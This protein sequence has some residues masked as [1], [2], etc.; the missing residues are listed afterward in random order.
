MSL[1]LGSLKPDANTTLTTLGAAV[2][3][4]LN[5]YFRT[6]TEVG[7]A[8]VVILVYILSNFVPSKFIDKNHNEDLDG[9]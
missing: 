4:V 7:L 3:T 2:A 1:N 8:I 5:Y 9:N 6:P